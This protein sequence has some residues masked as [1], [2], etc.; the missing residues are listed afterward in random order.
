MS[1]TLRPDYVGIQLFTVVC[2][3][4]CWCWWCKSTARHNWMC[5]WNFKQRIL[6]S[7][8]RSH[9]SIPQ[10]R[11][12]FFFLLLNL[13]NGRQ[14]NHKPASKRIE[15]AIVNETNACPTTTKKKCAT[16]NTMVYWFLFFPLQI[17]VFNRSFYKNPVTFF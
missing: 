1:N 13:N 14:P 12:F 17:E 7:M 10:M 15:H 16:Q 9:L 3:V 2:A 6:G 11:F 8:T 5:S 4:L